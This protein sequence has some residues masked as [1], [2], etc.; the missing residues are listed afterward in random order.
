MPRIRP[1]AS[2]SALSGVRASVTGTALKTLVAA[3][4]EGVAGGDGERM[5]QRAAGELLGEPALEEQRRGGDEVVAGGGR[6]SRQAGITSDLVRVDLV[7]QK[8]R[9]TLGGHVGVGGRVVADVVKQFGVI[10]GELA[11]GV[12]GGEG[13]VEDDRRVEFGVVQ[14]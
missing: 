5:Q 2:P 10:D 14:W 1:L 4:Q 11:L 9:Q 7:G 6:H 3:D 8:H 12:D 13:A